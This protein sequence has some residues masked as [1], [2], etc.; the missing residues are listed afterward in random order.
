[1]IELK[2]AVGTRFEWRQPEAFRRFHELTADGRT[3][4]SL[5][6]EKGCGTLATAAYG[7]ARWTFKRSGFWS[8]RVSVR[9]PGSQTDLAVFT[10]RWTGGG[11]LAFAAGRRFQLKSLSFWGGEWAFET[12]DGSEV[13]SVHGPHGLVRNSGEAALGLSAAR[14]P[15]T[16]ILLLL[17]W[18]L[19]LLMQD[20]AA[21][22]TAATAV[23]CG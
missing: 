1:V 6:F 22:T 2:Q 11:E 9:E 5:R 4:A 18:Y 8:P 20:D 15:E 7:D 10:P 21:A 23:C 17:I 16:P 14:L 12:E 3:V 13:V 19:R